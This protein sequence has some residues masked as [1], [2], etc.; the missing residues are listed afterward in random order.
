M[1]TN[2]IDENTY[3][4]NDT[5]KISEVDLGTNTGYTK[6]N[7]EIDI[8]AV[9]TIE[10]E[11]YG[12][13]HFSIYCGD[14]KSMRVNSNTPTNSLTVEQDGVQYTLEA[15]LETVDGVTQLTVTVPNAPD[16]TLPILLKKYNKNDNTQ[17]T[18]GWLAAIS[19]KDTGK[20][21]QVKTISN[22]ELGYEDRLEASATS[23][24][25]IVN[26]TRAPVGMINA[27]SHIS[28]VTER[29]ERHLGGSGMNTNQLSFDE[30][31]FKGKYVLLFDDVITRGDSMRTFKSKME[32]LGAIVVGG[33]ALGKTKHE[34]PLSANLQ[35]PPFDFDDLPF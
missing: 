30:D 25:Y 6:L 23:V 7:K 32:T 26:E 24:T 14:G 18:T 2:S 12:I 4:T 35:R 28:V 33:L 27:Y 29:E 15:K 22:G 11:K 34:R 16:N 9:K 10:N 13:K 1:L 19:N 8:V 20:Y 21:V 3:R 31:F 5:Y 17:T